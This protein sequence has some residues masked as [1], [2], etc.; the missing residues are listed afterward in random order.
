MVRL[1]ENDT[2]GLY[3]KPDS[4]IE[5]VQPQRPR[6]RWPWMLLLGALAT[7]VL[8][9]G[10]SP[11]DC[12]GGA[13]SS[14]HTAARLE[15]AKCP[16]QPPAR[17]AG[18]HWDIL[19]DDMYADLASQRLSKA[20]QHNTESFDY[21]IQVPANDTSFDK[22]YAFADW[23]YG[24][25]PKVFNDA[26]GKIKHEVVNTHGQLLTYKGS[27]PDLQPIVLMAHLD[28]VPVLEATESQWRYPPFAG[29][30]TT[31]GTADTPGKWIWGRGASD[32]KNSLMGIYGAFERLVTEGFEPERTII[33]ASGFDEEVSLSQQSDL[34]RVPLTKRVT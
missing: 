6:A 8:R 34:P 15:A 2:R 26:T 27:N 13:A 30:I 23:L 33:V 3:E 20:V 10:H 22:H 32:C 16:A 5:P 4:S 25:F 14:A 17:H 29:S 12:M 11:L 28:T 24:E 21:M 7:V 18:K 9:T 1:E 19:H 31:D